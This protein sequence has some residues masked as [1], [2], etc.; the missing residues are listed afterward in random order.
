[1]RTGSVVQGMIPAGLI[2]LTTIAHSVGVIRLT[3]RNTF[4][5]DMYS[6]E[7]LA[8]VDVLCLDKT[9]TITDGRMTVVKDVMLTDKHPHS[10][11]DIIGCMENVLDDSN[12]TA[13]A[14]RSYYL[15]KNEFTASKIL[16]FSSARKYSAVTFADIGTYVLGAPE[17]ILHDIPEKIS[18]EIE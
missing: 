4:V 11:N 12:Q 18:E 8:R 14:L 10:L 5:Q 16:P 2:L 7:N 17:F 1:M 13:I 6:L 15:P 9:G 3:K